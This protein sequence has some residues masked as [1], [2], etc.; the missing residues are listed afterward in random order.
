MGKDYKPCK[1]FQN[2]YKMASSTWVSPEEYERREKYLRAGLREVNLMDP[3]TWS[4][5]YQGAALMFG[6]S[7]LTGKLYDMW[8]KKPFYFA[9][10]PK[11]MA[12][13]TITLMGFGMGKLREYHYRTRDAVMQHY[14]ELHPEDFDHFQDSEY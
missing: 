5:P 12:V 13:A 11:A 9:L 2:V 10:V 1:F 14:I 7:M 3:Y 8:N 4:R 6:L